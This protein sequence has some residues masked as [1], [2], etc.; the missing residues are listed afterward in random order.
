MTLAYP[1]LL[2]LLPLPLALRYL[3]PA[4]RTSTSGVR[5]PQ[6]DLVVRVSGEEP[7]SGSSIR[8]RSFWQAAVY[9]FVWISLVIAAARPQKLLPP[10]SKELPTRDLML[11]IDLSGSMETKDFQS[12]T[13]EVVTRLVAVQQTLDDF[14]TQRNGDRVSMIVFGSGAFVQIPFTQDVDVCRQLVDQLAV[15]MAGPKTAFGDA[16]GLAITVFQRSQMEDKVLIA[17]TDGNDT[18]SRVP[19]I[20]AAKIAKDNGIIIHTIGIGDPTAAGEDA[21]DEEALRTVAET[22][23]GKYFY[24]AD[25]KQLKL[26]YS[27]L[28]SMSERKI[29]TLSYRP[30]LERYHVF[31][32]VALVTSLLYFGVGFAK[33]LASH[34]IELADQPPSNAIEHISRD[35]N[36][37][38][39]A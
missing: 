24:A 16:I 25:Q 38:Q 10:I 29:E 35:T 2:V 9:A 6:F 21:M 11:A 1:W 14:L 8:R 7:S 4:H 3:L 13:G 12:P 31:V 27:E 18:G 28:D 23:S 39:I 26:V 30:R 32:A 19:P 33:G 15:R 36:E 22:T 5:V 37:E 17:L 34:V 20:E